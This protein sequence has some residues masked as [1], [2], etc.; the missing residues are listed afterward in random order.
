[1]AFMSGVVGAAITAP[2]DQQD[3]KEMIGS[4]ERR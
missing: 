1:V 3:L 4:A 2:S